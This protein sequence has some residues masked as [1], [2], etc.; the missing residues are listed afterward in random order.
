M[1][2]LCVVLCL[3]LTG[4][5]GTILSHKPY[6]LQGGT[7]VES[8]PRR[9]VTSYSRREAYIAATGEPGLVTGDMVTNVCPE[10]VPAVGVKVKQVR[11]SWDKPRKCWRWESQ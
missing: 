2:T 4:C 5:A 1:K 8:S 6:S 3:L 10:T 9:V 7:V 11:L